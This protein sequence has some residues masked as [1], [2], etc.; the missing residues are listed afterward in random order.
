MRVRRKSDGQLGFLV[1]I[2]GARAVRLDRGTHIMAESRVVPYDANDWEHDKGPRLSPLGVA[3]VCYDADRALRL[4]RGEYG[5]TEWIS[6]QSKSPAAAQ[7]WIEGPP[8]DADEG[9][10]KLFAA[11]VEA[12][13]DE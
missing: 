8:A 1:D 12:L 5:I 3:R 7:A 9:R 4:A 10:K 11:V 2:K 6:L 13:A